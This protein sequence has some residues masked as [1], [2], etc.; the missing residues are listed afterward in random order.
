[1][2]NL[3]FC[4]FCGCS[5]AGDYCPHCNSEQRTPL[6]ECEGCTNIPARGELICG[7]C[8]NRLESRDIPGFPEDPY[9]VWQKEID[10]GGEGLDPDEDLYPDM[11]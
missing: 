5:I 4:K 11:D 8:W 1:M 7:E 9:E 10:R 2:N 6:C 3:D